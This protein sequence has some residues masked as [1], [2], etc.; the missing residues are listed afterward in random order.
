[1]IFF[2]STRQNRF[3]MDR[4]LGGWGG[5]LRDVVQPIA[6]ETFLNYER[7]GPGVY[8]FADLEL[9]TAPQRRKAV[10]IWDQLDQQVTNTILFNHP[11]RALLRY[12]LLKCLRA[13]KL[14]TFN[15]YRPDEDFSQIR[16]PVFIR[17]EN[18]HRGNASDLLEDTAEL[19]QTIDRLRAAR[20]AD[21]GWLITE[22]CDTS[23]PDGIFRKYS[24]FMV[25]G[26]V[27]PR[28]LFF[29]RRKWCLKAADLVDQELLEEERA[30]LHENPH[31][32]QIRSV[33][34]IAG[35]N[36]GRV[37]YGMLGDSVQ[38][39]EI[40]TNPMLASSYSFL[41]RSLRATWQ[42]LSLSS[43]R[44]SSASQTHRLDVHR[45]FAQRLSGVVRE[46]A[47]SPPARCRDNY[48]WQRISATVHRLRNAPLW[49]R[50]VGLEARLKRRLDRAQQ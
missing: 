19:Q 18:D 5:G 21:P 44:R 13:R 45:V 40:N 29:S 16:F 11:T 15:I 25:N 9:L 17:V 34:E 28:H 8:I 23:G 47:E 3:P 14:N 1:M 12:E 39:W 10:E 20:P 41:D 30:Y 33:F 32:E 26:K 46:L 42:S 31:E 6:Y 7:F 48:P 43:G 24:A 50:I 36:Y 35:I 4:F 38:V 22:F 49:R 27:I 37:D 2:L